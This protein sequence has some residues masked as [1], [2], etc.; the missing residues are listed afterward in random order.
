M[1]I[2]RNIENYHKSIGAQ[3]KSVQNQVRDL[4]GNANWSEDGRFKESIVRKIIRERIG[5][6]YHVGTGFV[7]C[8]S[9]L[10]TQIDILITRNDTP[11]LF[12]EGDFKIVTSDAAAA[13][14]EIKTK[15]AQKTELF[16][17]LVKISDAAKLIRDDVKWS[18]KAGLFI[19]DDATYCETDFFNNFPEQLLKKHCEIN[20][21]CIG[22]QYFVRYWRKNDSISINGTVKEITVPQYRLYKIPSL[23][24]SYFISNVVLDTNRNTNFNFQDAWFPLDGGKEERFVCGYSQNGKNVNQEGQEI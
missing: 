6:A 19:F 12:S 5:S 20:W 24:Y 22:E 16:E 18:Y 13:I 10:T 23:A 2:M 4:I 17:T 9:N 21:F 7:L 15:Q 1:T 8:K 3:I 11:V 14:I